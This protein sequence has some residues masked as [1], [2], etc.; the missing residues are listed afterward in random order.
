MSVY[1]SPKSPFYAFDFKLGGHRFHGTTKATNRKAAEAVERELKVKAKA[2]VETA[3]RAGNGPL[4]LDDAAGRYWNEVGQHHRDHK[5]TWHAMELLIKHFGPNRRLDEIDD[6]RVSG[7]VG[8][9]RQH[10]VKGRGLKPVS[11]ATVNRSVVEPLRKLFIHAKTVWRYQFPREPLW[12]KH[13]LKEPP[14]RVR[15]LH[16]GEA[17]ALAGALRPDF[18]P[19]FRFASATG[20]RLAETLIKWDMVNWEAGSIVTTGKGGRSRHHAH[21]P[22]RS[23]PPSPAAGPS[24]RVGLHLRR[25]A[26]T[27][28]PAPGRA[29]PA[30]LCRREVGMAGHAQAGG[31]QGVPLSRRAA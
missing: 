4:T 7:L 21:Y 22:R 13:R 17:D 25:S 27:G 26:A 29:R 11:N 2:D 18:E 28:G 10:T 23:G 30:D 20:L 8:W 24:S 1:K 5:G 19:W 9:R 3:T 15:E 6:A 14:E 31:R 16:A 12:R